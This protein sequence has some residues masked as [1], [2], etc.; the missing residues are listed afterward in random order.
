MDYF[1]E[2]EEKKFEEFNGLCKKYKIPVMESFIN[3]KVT[4]KDGN[5][6][7][8]INTRSHSWVRNAYN[9]FFC[10]F[11]GA[12]QTITTVFGDGYLTFKD[13]S[14]IIYGNIINY[15]SYWGYFNNAGDN[16]RGIVVGSSD[17]AE[18]FESYKLS[19]T[20][21][22]GYTTGLLAYLASDIPTISYVSGTKT[23]NITADRYINNNSGGN[24]IVKEV[25]L[26]AYF[27]AKCLF[28]RDVLPAEVILEDADQ[29]YASYTLSI[30]F[31][32]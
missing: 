8:E 15:C 12:N 14:N 19:C 28:S 20:I 26:I 30:Q 7:D 13:T 25:G 10:N 5:L 4:D 31:P 9:T 16:S 24:V 21:T 22:H 18:S 11:V 2:E 17:V 3:I 32:E 1:I 6:K 23:Y 27:Y 29:L